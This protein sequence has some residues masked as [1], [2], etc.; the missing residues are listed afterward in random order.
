MSGDT[1]TSAQPAASLPRT[2][3]EDWVRAL[4][5]TVPLRTPAQLGQLQFHCGKPPPA[6]A[7]STLIFMASTAGEEGNETPPA[8]AGRRHSI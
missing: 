3:I 8:R 6:A 2:A 4:A 1:L 5:R 7:P